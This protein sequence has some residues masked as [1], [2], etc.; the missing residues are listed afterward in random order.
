MSLKH[1]LALSLILVTIIGGSFT[2]CAK[3]QGALPQYSLGDKWVSKWHTGGQDY[4]VTTEV[5]GSEVVDGKDCYVMELTF[6]P[7]YQS[8]V[9]VINK[10]D[11]A[12]TNIVYED[13]KMTDPGDFNTVVYEVTGDDAYPLTVGK[14]YKQVS[15]MTFTSGNA[16][17]SS[18]QNSTTT[19]TT[20]VEGIE[21]V[22]VPA[23]TFRC[24]KLVKY[25]EQGNITQITWRPAATKFF[26]VKMSD[27]TQPDD[28]YELVSYSVK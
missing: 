11:K 4:T 5:T 7:P 20:K 6:D 22:T 25:D 1:L 15:L 23:G 21:T 26:Q 28:T 2:S 14:V 18:S 17:I 19:T 24:F 10:Y 16:T 12:T 9:S 8:L 3:E 13:M 27:P